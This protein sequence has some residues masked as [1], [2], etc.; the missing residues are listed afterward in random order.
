MKGKDY[1]PRIADEM[2]RKRLHRIGAV[3][4][5]GPKWCGKTTTSEQM[6]NSVLYMADPSKQKAYLQMAELNASM[7][8]TGETPRLI[9][10]WQLAPKIWDAV[11]FEVDHRGE[12]GLF[13]LTGSAVPPST[14][15]INH[16]GTGRISRLTMRPMSLF[17]SGESN[18]NVSLEWLFSQPENQPTGIA[19]LSINDL[20]FLICRGGWPSSTTKQNEEDALALAFDYFDAVTEAD[21]SRVDGVKR[22]PEKA[23]LLMR[24]YARHQGTQTSVE[25]IKQDMQAH[26][27]S[28]ISEYS[29]IS[30]I[31]AL[32]K[33]F[34]IEN[35]AAWN[36]NLRSKTAIRT[37]ETRYFV[38]PSIATAALGLGPSDLL[39]DLNTM[40]LFFETLA[41]RD[42]RVYADALDGKVYHYRDKT[43]LECDAVLHLRNGQYGLIEIKLGGDKLI[44]EGV[45]TLTD[46]SKKIDTTKMPNPSFLMVLTGIG[47][48]AYRR[49]DGVYVVPIG[50]LRA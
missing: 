17:E 29:I 2:L 22:D 45:K 34:V 40:G 44:E 39:N 26:D 38:D 20:A 50:C 1:K 46:L 5:Q 31:D 49:A 11:R 41:V 24:S 8:L 32:K 12:D 6:S 16:T 23:G 27:D 14:E 48:Y 4:V 15:G 37:S 9:D 21:I 35:M 43:G 13:I 36:P 18:G 10:E 3:L 7:L 47:D 33:I 25:I 28:S 42:L 30:Y 19:N